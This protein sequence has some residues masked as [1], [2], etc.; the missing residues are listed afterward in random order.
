MVPELAIALC[1]SIFI[2]FSILNSIQTLKKTITK[3]KTVY[4]WPN[5]LAS[6]GIL[7]YLPVEY[8]WDILC[9]KTK[10]RFK[11]KNPPNNIAAF[12]K[13]STDSKIFSNFKLVF[14]KWNEFKTKS[15]LKEYKLSIFYLFD[16][17]FLFKGIK[18]RKWVQKSDIFKI[19]KL[20]LL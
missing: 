18:L 14:S 3:N 5:F 11:F 7:I 20:I 13:K 17:F 15:N 4:F 2:F 1:L 6:N 12:W 8:L 19:N 16:N 10:P 9:D